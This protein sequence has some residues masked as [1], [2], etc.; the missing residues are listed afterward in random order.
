[1]SDVYYCLHTRHKKKKYLILSCVSLF[2]T[3][4]LRHMPQKGPWVDFVKDFR[5]S[6]KFS[7]LI[8]DSMVWYLLASK[9]EQVITSCGDFPNVPLMGPR[10]CINYN[11][12]LALRKL[13]YLMETEPKSKLLKDFFLPDLGTENP[14]LLQK[15]KQ[16]WT[17]IHRKD[18]FSI[19]K[20]YYMCQSL[21]FL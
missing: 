21:N 6:Q 1:M 11:P 5:W 16:A 17:L 12:W 10:G 13:G 18:N 2:Y 3:W 7:S 19:T 20:W 8:A 14:N 4:I 9:I 15:I